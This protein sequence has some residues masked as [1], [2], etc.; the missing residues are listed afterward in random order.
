MDVSIIPLLS[1][2]DHQ[3]AGSDLDSINMGLIHRVKLVLILGAITGNDTLVQLYAGA[4]AGTKTTELP[5]SYRLSG[6]DTGN[7]SADTYAAA[8]AVAAGASGL[9]FADSADFSDRCI[10][11]DVKSDDLPAGLEWLTVAVDDGSASELL[12]G[13]IAV[14]W[15]RYE[16]TSIPTAL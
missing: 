12:L 7:A 3:S 2:A 16:G 15:P 10:T 4:T 14:A 13:A 5:F 6:A 11:I 9:V 1:P 8:V